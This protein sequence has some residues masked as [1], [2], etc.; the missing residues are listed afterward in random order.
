MFTTSLSAQAVE[1]NVF[2]YL[3][4][5]ETDQVQL[6]VLPGGRLYPGGNPMFDRL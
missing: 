5:N 2:G 1:P 4:V 6:L 3:T